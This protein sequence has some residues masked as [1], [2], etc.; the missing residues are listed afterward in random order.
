VSAGSLTARD[1][2]LLI[3]CVERAV[4]SPRRVMSFE[5]GHE[6]EVAHQL[7]GNA[8]LEG[9]ELLYKLRG[10]AREAAP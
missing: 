5:I 3:E 2:E 9:H 7:R 6:V 4:T 1:Y 10:L 8:R